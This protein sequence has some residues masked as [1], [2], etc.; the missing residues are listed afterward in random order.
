MIGLDTNVLIRYL[1]NDD[2]IQSKV[3]SDFI[4]SFQNKPESFFVSHIVLCE[5]D[6]VLKRAYGISKD[7]RL[8]ILE[9]ILDTFEFK[10]K[11]LEIAKDALKLSHDSGLDFADALIGFL[12]ISTGCKYTVTFDKNAAKSRLF[13]LLKSE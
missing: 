8:R 11:N 12:G 3:A 2:P 1:V 6:W 7:I 13:S 9:E 10:I 4:E 5:I